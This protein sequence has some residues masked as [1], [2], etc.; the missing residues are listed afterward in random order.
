V[1]DVVGGIGLNIVQLSGGAIHTWK[2]PFINQYLKIEF[3]KQLDRYTRAADV[4]S[5][6]RAL[7]PTSSRRSFTIRH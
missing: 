4:G 3:E 2:G 6:S 7:F 1:T 5:S